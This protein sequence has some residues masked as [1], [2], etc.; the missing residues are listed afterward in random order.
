[1]DSTIVTD[2]VAAKELM[3]PYKIMLMVFGLIT[4]WGVN[5]LL[6]RFVQSLMESIP[7]KRLLILQVFTLFSFT[8]YIGGTVLLVGG[9]VRP[10][11]ELLIAL[12]GSAA[13]ATGIALKDVAAS[14]VAGVLLLFDRPFRV[15]DRVS[16]DGIYGEIVSI[17]LRIVRL[18]TLDDN[19][20]TIPNSRF[21]TETVASGNAG[22]LE[23]MVVM[24]FH[25]TLAANITVATTII[26]EVIITSRFAYLRKPVTF[27][28]EELVLA[29]RA[30]MRIRAKAY[31]LDVKYEK[32]FQT[33][34]ITR[35]TELFQ[36]KQIPR[37]D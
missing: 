31:V 32:A 29:N 2:F 33:D 11:T 18:Q 34:V 27:A 17:G 9:I 1:M 28:V 10:P 35:S 3:N 23:M 8:W 37:P 36:A 22:A 5:T 26:R 20:V 6:R 12:G 7:G 13:V 4:L 14:L 25:F 15:G 16:F 30:M 19:L 21:I 24:D